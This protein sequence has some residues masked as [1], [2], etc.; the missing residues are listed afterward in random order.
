MAMIRECG[1]GGVVAAVRRMA[2]FRPPSHAA[3]KLTFRRVVLR[4]ARACRL[5]NL[6]GEALRSDAMFE[7][8]MSI[9]A[10]EQ[11]GLNGPLSWWQR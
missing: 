1:G 5:Q 10:C 7:A 11:G 8:A 6:C 4:S 3:H 9:G 2:V